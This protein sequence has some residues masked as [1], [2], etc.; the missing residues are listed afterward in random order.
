MIPKELLTNSKS[1]VIRSTNKHTTRKVDRKI[2]MR[3]FYLQEI[4][5]IDC[6]VA[7][8]NDKIDPRCLIAIRLEDDKTDCRACGL[9]MTD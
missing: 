8:R 7:T 5:L 3:V 6:F 9:A 1:L 2:E 4:D